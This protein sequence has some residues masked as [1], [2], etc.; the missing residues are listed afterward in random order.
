M[1]AAAPV[2]DLSRPVV[3]DQVPADGRPLTVRAT[4]EECAAVADRLGLDGLDRLDGRLTV[5]PLGARRGVTRMELT[6]AFDADVRQTCVVSLA[7][8][9]RSVT[10]T[11]HVRYSTAADDPATTDRG[12]VSVEPDGDAADDPPDPI[13]DGVID[14]GAALVEALALAV[15]PHPRAEGAVFDA[16]AWSAGPGESDGADPEGGA[17][18]GPFAALAAL[19]TPQGD[20]GTS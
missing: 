18:P 11:L 3:V 9:H 19:R 6:G 20:R 15:D 12:E 5:R 10:G 7:P 13:V 17:S 1:T 14:V 8:L 4:A 16:A 2:S